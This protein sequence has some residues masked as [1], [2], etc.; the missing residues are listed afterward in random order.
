MKTTTTSNDASAHRVQIKFGPKWN[1]NSIDT[2]L[3]EM[4]GKRVLV[5][6]SPEKLIVGRLGRNSFCNQTLC[7]TTGQGDED[8]YGKFFFEPSQ[9]DISEIL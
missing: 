2:T 3:E 8:L 9:A 4:M 1:G 6:F 7:I 5:Q